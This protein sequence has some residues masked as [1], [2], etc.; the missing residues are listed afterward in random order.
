MFS[1]TKQ[2]TNNKY[3]SMKTNAKMKKNVHR[4]LISHGQIITHELVSWIMPITI[5]GRAMDIKYK[6]IIQGVGLIE[7]AKILIEEKT[8]F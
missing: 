6:N 1:S 3:F 8:K 2:Y 5:I 4:A 7:L